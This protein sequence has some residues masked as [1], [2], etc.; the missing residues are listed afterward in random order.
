MRKSFLLFTGI[1]LVV[2]VTLVARKQRHDGIIDDTRPAAVVLAAAADEVRFDWK[3]EACPP[4]NSAV[5]A[6]WTR[7]LA[8][9]KASSSRAGELLASDDPDVQLLNA[10]VRNQV[11]F[12]TDRRVACLKRRGEVLDAMRAVYQSK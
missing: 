8:D 2:L 7:R 4:E 9:A 11:I 12:I 6:E 5:Y 3:S 10:K 1:L